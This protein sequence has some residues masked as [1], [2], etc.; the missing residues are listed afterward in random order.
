MPIV[1]PLEQAGAWSEAVSHE[2]PEKEA[3]EERASAVLP[4]G[5]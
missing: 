5:K 4:K 1:Y 2:V 3:V